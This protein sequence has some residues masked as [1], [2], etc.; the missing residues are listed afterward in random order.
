MLVLLNCMCKRLHT[1]WCIS[2]FTLL[3]LWVLCLRCSCQGRSSRFHWWF[4][5]DVMLLGNVLVGFQPVAYCMFEQRFQCAWGVQ[6]ARPEISPKA[7]AS[8]LKTSCDMKWLKFELMWCSF[9]SNLSG[10]I[11]QFDGF[12]PKSTLRHAPIRQIYLKRC[13]VSKSRNFCWPESPVRKWRAL[14]IDCVVLFGHWD[15]ISANIKSVQ[16]RADFG[17][18]PGTISASS[19]DPKNSTA[20]GLGSFNVFLNFG[21]LRFLGVRGR[22]G[23]CWISAR[24]SMMLFDC[25]QCPW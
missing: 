18:I 7:L 19:Y 13:I 9:T 16:F 5:G 15:S 12:Q 8:E 17:S 20:G 22:F 4:R 6:E 3:P 1:W 2:A 23:T 24:W 11:W 25:H 10:F 21:M 14:E